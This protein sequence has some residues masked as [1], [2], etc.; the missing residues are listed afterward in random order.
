MRHASHRHTHAALRWLLLTGAAAARI[1]AAQAGAVETGVVQTSLQQAMLRS[2]PP[3]V[4]TGNAVDETVTAPPSTSVEAALQQIAAQAGVVFTGSVSAV[5]AEVGGGARVTFQVERGLRGVAS[6]AEYRVHVSA[7]A[8]GASRFYPGERALF[9][10]TTPSVAGFSAPVMG[11]R[12][13]VPLSGDALVGNVDLQWVAADVQRGAPITLEVA[14]SVH[15]A[16]LT[17]SAAQ[18][19]ASAAG[20]TSSD[21]LTLPDVHAIDRDLVLDLL[22]FATSSP[23]A[24]PGQVSSGQARSGQTRS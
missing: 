4:A 24:G 10:L 19:P 22:R 21:S 12:G 17:L 1:A 14:P 8:G 13:I 7:W 23:G 5:Q 3:V 9:L 18:A 16:V 15:A 2:A 6:G 11:E 20:A